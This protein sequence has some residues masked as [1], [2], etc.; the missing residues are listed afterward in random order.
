MTERFKITAERTFRSLRNDNYR[1]YFFGQLVSMTGTWMQ[2]VAQ[3]WLVLS[4][5]GSAVALGVTSALQFAPM[6]LFGAWGGVV[7]DRFDKRRVLLITQSAGAVL[8]LCLGA[9]AITGVAT[10][11]M[12]YALT[13]AWGIVI[14]IDNP[15]R[16]SFLS[17]LVDREDLP[18]AVGLNSAI[19][20]AARTAGPALAG[21]VI[22]VAGVGLCFVLNGLSYLAT[23]GAL[24]RLDTTK[25]D[26]PERTSST[27]GRLREGLA[28][29][30][31]TPE[32]RSPLLLMAVIGTLAYNFR[33]FVPL[34]ASEVFAGGPATLGMLSAMMGAG[35]IVG[36]LVVASRVAPGRRMLL[37]SGLA[38][39]FTTL[40]VAW[41]PTLS[42]ELVAIAPMGAVSVVYAATTNSILQLN[43]APEMRGRVMAL[44]AVVFLG[45]TPIGG[46]LMGWIAEMLGVRGALA[47]AGGATMIAALV[48]GRRKIGAE[49]HSARDRI[50]ALRTAGP[51]MTLSPWAS[52]TSTSTG[53]ERSLAPHPLPHSIRRLRRAASAPSSDPDRR[54][55]SSRASRPRSAQNGPEQESPRR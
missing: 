7:A 43:S 55:R 14:M 32:L 44:Y 15:T 10:L 36:A 47:I 17:E 33:M 28:Y 3:M 11:W 30:R 5:T 54:R 41:A 8:A 25:L 39:G 4:L 12:V 37:L 34:L 29:V 22:S 16:Q 26:R 31:R 35:T 48:A 20:T 40:L 1:R 50:G 13:A 27:K 19:V 6:L 9:V 23:I 42:W 38:F 51:R 2:S 53:E 52:E 21:I 24:L 49:L 46:P 45:S 18:N